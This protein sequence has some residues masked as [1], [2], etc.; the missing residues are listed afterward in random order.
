MNILRL[1]FWLLATFTMTL[2]MTYGGD[3]ASSGRESY[4]ENEE[5]YQWISHLIGALD[6]KPNQIMV[7]RTLEKQW[8]EQT[9][10]K[11]KDAP[12]N[13]KCP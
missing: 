11:D 6:L 4:D 10:S 8:I 5:F 2:N 9:K 12:D 7:D 1:A 3:T 13:P